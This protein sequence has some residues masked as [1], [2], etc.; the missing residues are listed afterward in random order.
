MNRSTEGSLLSIRYPSSSQ[1][2]DY[3][4]LRVCLVKEVATMLKTIGPTTVTSVFFGGGLVCDQT[5]TASP[6]IRD[7]YPLDIQNMNKC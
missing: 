5:G 2:S 4:R 7:I 3:K 6:A 1:G